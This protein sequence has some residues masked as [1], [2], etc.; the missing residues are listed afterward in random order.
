MEKQYFY[1]GE[2]LVAAR[3][4]AREFATKYN[5]LRGVVPPDIPPEVRDTLRHWF[6]HAADYALD[7]YRA[8]FA[9]YYGK[10][11]PE[12]FNT[13]RKLGFQA[14]MRAPIGAPVLV[15]NY[16]IGIEDCKALAALDG[17]HLNWPIVDEYLTMYNDTIRKTEDATM[18]EYLRMFNA[19]TDYHATMT[20]MH[21]GNPST[22]PDGP[23]K[24]GSVRQRKWEALQ[25]AT[26]EYQ[27]AARA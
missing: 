6:G 22:W 3:K 15:D 27:A 13:A 19:Q 21:G 4:L 17:G 23:F 12:Q 24:P 2:E 16:A 9:C 20:R 26:A 11:S 5:R 8:R 18:T 14:A 1:R 25:K 7:E 10:M